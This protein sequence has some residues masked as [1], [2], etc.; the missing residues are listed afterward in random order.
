MHYDFQI[1]YV[2]AGRK[3][4]GLRLFIKFE[5]NDKIYII[6]KNKYNAQNVVVHK[7][8]CITKKDMATEGD[9]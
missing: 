2:K 7:F 1:I 3:L 4:S 9:V 6:W 8:S 5:K